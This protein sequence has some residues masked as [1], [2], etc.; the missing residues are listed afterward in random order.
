MKIFAVRDPYAINRNLEQ[1]K[2]VGNPIRTLIEIEMTGVRTLFHPA[3]EKHRCATTRKCQ[4]LAADIPYT[5]QVEMNV[6]S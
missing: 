4:Q 2:S 1:I 3:V 6:D 5:M